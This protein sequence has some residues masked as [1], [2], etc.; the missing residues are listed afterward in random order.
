MG[1]TYFELDV[2]DEVFQSWHEIKELESRS[3]SK[4]FGCYGQTGEGFLDTLVSKLLVLID[5]DTK[6]IPLVKHILH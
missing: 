1:W 4:A 2:S 5:N 6:E 3:G